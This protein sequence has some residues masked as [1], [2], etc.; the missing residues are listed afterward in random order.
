MS[1]LSTRVVDVEALLPA[2]VAQSCWLADSLSDSETPTM[3]SGFPSLDS[4]LPSGG[5][6]LSALTEVLVPQFACAELR[7]LLPAVEG[8]ASR[9]APLVMVAP[10]H[11]PFIGG[12]RRYG[13]HE[14][15]VVVVD[16]A[17]PA[18]RLWATEQAVRAQGL[19]GIVS[20]LPNARPE[21]IR[22]L[23]TCAPG[24]GFPIFLIRPG[25]ALHQSSAAPLRVEARHDGPA[26]LTVRVAKR[27]GPAHTD[28][29]RLGAPPPGFGLLQA[30]P[31]LAVRGLPLDLH[32]RTDP[33]TSRRAQNVPATPLA[34]AVAAAE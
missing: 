14:D 21:Q 9:N 12:L 18:D 16:V 29:L 6:P 33:S 1:S 24:S 20:W 7:L 4:L 13:I 17:K 34:G 22:R 19:A 5:W 8:L 27:R 23:Q 10:P 28:W 3:P 32:P 26:H 15:A 25:A 11:R 2:E 30:R 31:S